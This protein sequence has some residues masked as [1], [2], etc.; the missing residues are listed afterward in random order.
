[1]ARYQMFLWDKMG[2]L[3]HHL[4]AEQHDAAE[5]L[6]AEAEKRWHGTV[7]TVMGRPEPPPGKWGLPSTLKYPGGKALPLVP[8]TIPSF[9]AKVP[10]LP[11]RTSRPGKNYPQD[12]ETVPFP[13]ILLGLATTPR[14]FTKC[15]AVPCAHLRLQG[16][17][18]FPQL[19]DWLF[20]VP[21]RGDLAQAVH[22]THSLLQNLGFYINHDKF[23]LSPTQS[24][25]FTGA[26]LDSLPTKVFL[27]QPWVETLAS[28]A[29]AVRTIAHS[30]QRLLG[31]KAARLL[32]VHLACLLRWNK[33]FFHAFPPLPLITK[34]IA[35][36][37]K[38]HMNHL[39]IIPWWTQ[40]LMLPHLL[41]LPP[42]PLLTKVIAKSRR[43]T[44]IVSLSP[45]GGLN[46]CGS[47]SSSCPTGHSSTCH[48]T[49]TCS[50]RWR[51]RCSIQTSGPQ[52]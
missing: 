2:S 39:F 14:V 22:T 7:W 17:Q 35:K 40:Q 18:V 26:C 31:F 32:V 37:Q 47:L 29:M 49:T 45:S 43:D 24:I 38:D 13:L 11:K 27:S 52:T 25:S 19:D 16:V 5:Q 44:Q 33:T 30:I 50:L 21:S 8:A 12:Q 15:M 6:H 4:L 23:V 10:A 36:I 46:S 51:A 9:K 41:Y 42:F 28:L 3:A 20:T 1:M 48:R 34:V